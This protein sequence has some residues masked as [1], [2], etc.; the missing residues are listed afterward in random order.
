MKPGGGGWPAPGHPAGWRELAGPRASLPRPGPGLRCVRDVPRGARGPQLGR[1]SRDPCP[2]GP[3]PT[4]LQDRAA[5]P[6]SRPPGARPPRA[7]LLPRLRFQRRAP[8]P[9][10]PAPPIAASAGAGAG[11]GPLPGSGALPGVGSGW[12]PEIPPGLLIPP[13][14]GCLSSGIGRLAVPPCIGSFIHSAQFTGTRPPG[15]PHLGSSKSR[16]GGTGVARG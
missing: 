11:S 5:L 10:A 7:T 6:E 16:G 13:P 2:E 3:G 12:N 4:H 8:P 15:P 14:W 1:P 9:A